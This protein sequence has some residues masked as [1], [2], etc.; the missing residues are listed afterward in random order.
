MEKTIY[1]A[2]QGA[3]RERLRE[4]R[5][6]AGMTQR[7]LAKVLRRDL[8]MV[9]RLETGQ[10]RA[11]LA[12]FF[13]ISRACGRIPR[14]AFLQLVTDFERLAPPHDAKRLPPGFGCRARGSCTQVS[15]PAHRSRRSGGA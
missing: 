8:N 12:E 13:W 4:M 5:L 1:T 15:K 6:A 10:R 11:D 3:I 2:F 9:H 7:D 14:K